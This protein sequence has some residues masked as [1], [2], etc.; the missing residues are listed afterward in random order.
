[1]IGLLYPFKYRR[2]Y[3]GGHDGPDPPRLCPKCGIAAE[4]NQR[5]C[6][7]CGTTLNVASNQPTAIASGEQSV[8]PSQ[9]AQF[10]TQPESGG[11]VPGNTSTA[12]TQVAARHLRQPPIALQLT[13][14]RSENSCKA[15]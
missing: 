3:Q 13:I 6:S 11:G 14:Q 9:G 8:I 7:E 1:M 12:P 2:N 10:A 5:F 15:E 4:P